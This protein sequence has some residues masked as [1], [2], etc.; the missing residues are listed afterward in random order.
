MEWPGENKFVYPIT[1]D[2]RNVQSTFLLKLLTL[3][4]DGD[5]L[6]NIFPECLSVI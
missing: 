6:E 1:I 2:Y 4:D 3:W 5:I